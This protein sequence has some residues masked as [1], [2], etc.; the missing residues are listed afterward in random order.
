MVAFTGATFA[1][2]VQAIKPG[3]YTS[4]QTSSAVDTGGGW[5]TLVVNVNA[6]TFT[7]DGAM[8]IKVQSATTSGGSYTDITGAAFTQITTANDDTCY[9]GSVKLDGSYGQYF[10]VVCTYAGTGNALLAVDLV[11]L[12]PEDS[13]LASSSFSV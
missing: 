5:G 12:L 11:F 9:L 6:G 1:K 2:A 8:T 13:A 4:T 3:T 7:G 10:K